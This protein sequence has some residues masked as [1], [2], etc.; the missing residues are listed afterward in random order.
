ML[1]HEH[2]FWQ[3]GSALHPVYVPT[4]PSDIVSFNTTEKKILF[5]ALFETV[6]EFRSKIRIFTPISSLY[7]L[8]IQLM[9]NP[10]AAYLCRGWIDFF[11]L[12]H[13]MAIRILAAIGAMK[14]LGNIGKS[15]GTKFTARAVFSCVS[16]NVFEIRQ[17]FWC[18]FCKSYPTLCGL[19]K[20]WKMILNISVYSGMISDTIVLVIFLMDVM[21]RIM[22]N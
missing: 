10:T 2:Q 6:P 14:I 15:T 19:S 16:G 3:R 11:L 12:I 4:S 5:V 18:L 20:K 7:A 17:S 1:P 8:T 9:D 22:I 21:H 13:V